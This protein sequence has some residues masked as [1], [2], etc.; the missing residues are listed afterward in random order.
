MRSE[1]FHDSQ[2]N[3]LDGE[4]L[5]GTS[6]TG[7]SNDDLAMDWLRYFIEHTR[8]KRRGAWLLLVID[9]F[10]SHLTIPF[11]KLATENQIVL[12]HLPAHSTHL[13]QPL[14]IGVFQLYKYYHAEAID[15]A[16]RM[17][18]ELG[19]LEFLAAFQEF[20]NKTIIYY[21]S[22]IQDHRHRPI[23]SKHDT[24]CHSSEASC[25]LGNYK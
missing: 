16:I 19:K 17:G 22:C 20:R 7:Y 2:H 4:T 24:R 12:F 8:T 13:T 25:S 21:S 14:D 15:H 11:L 5:I 6:E 3:D 1:A 23:Q 10:G 9:G 18:T